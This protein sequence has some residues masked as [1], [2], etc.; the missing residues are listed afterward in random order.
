MPPAKYLPSVLLSG[1]DGPGNPGFHRREGKHLKP[2]CIHTFAK[3]YGSKQSDPYNLSLYLV[4][5]GFGV[6]VPAVY[7]FIAAR[8]KGDFGLLATLSAGGRK[9]LAGASIAVAAAAIAKPL[10]PSRG[11]ASRTTLGLI[12]EPFGSE[13]L[14]LVSRK[15]EGFSAIRTGEGFLGVSH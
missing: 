13:E 11:T 14:L 6:A 7:R 1:N 3:L 9:H 5:S 8:L 2:Y 4:L 12:G 15:G 10:G